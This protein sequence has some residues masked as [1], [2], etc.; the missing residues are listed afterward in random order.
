MTSFAILGMSTSGLLLVIF[1]KG[2]LNMPRVVFDRDE[3]R[4]WVLM[5][6]LL[7]L[8]GVTM[9]VLAGLSAWIG[10]IR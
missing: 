10:V 2:M 8:T 4:R 7:D 1:A 6:V 9:L 3:N 5:L